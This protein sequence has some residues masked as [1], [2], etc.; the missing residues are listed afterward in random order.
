MKHSLL[1]LSILALLLTITTTCFAY[2]FE[3]D[4]IYY[5]ILS[6][7]KKI[8]EI[9]CYKNSVASNYSGD[10]VIPNNVEYGGGSYTVEVIGTYAFYCSGI[11]SISIPSSIKIINPGAFKNCQNLFSVEIPNSTEE[12]WE[13]AFYNCNRL[14]YISLPNSIKSIKKDAFGRCSNL[15]SVSINCKYV[16]SWFSNNY[17]LNTVLLGGNVEEIGNNAFSDCRTLTNVE[18]SNAI[19]KIGANAFHY[20]FS[21]TSIELPE[22]LEEIEDYAFSYCE[23]LSSIKLPNK[24]STIGCQAFAYCSALLSIEIPSH[25][26]SIGQGAFVGC[27]SLESISLPNSL[28]SLGWSAFEGCTSLE[29]VD[30]QEIT[31]LEGSLFKNCTALTSVT[32]HEGLVSIG[33]SAFDGCSSLKR[34]IIPKSVKSIGYDAFKGCSNLTLSILHENPIKLENEIGA[35]SLIVPKGSTVEYAKA[36]YWKEA[37]KIYALDGTTKRFPVFFEQYGATIITMD[38]NY[39]SGIEVSENESIR[40]KTNSDFSQCDLIMRGG[41]EITDSIINGEY[42]FQPSPYW[43]DNVIASYSYGKKIVDVTTSGTL[44]DIIGIENVN[45]IESIKINGELNGTDILTIR[46]M[47][48]LKLL[49]LKD[50]KIVN[51]GMSYYKEYVTSENKIGVYFFKDI[52]KLIHITLPTNIEDID[53]NLLGECP[54]LVSL[55]IPQNVTHIYQ[56]SN[57]EEDKTKSITFLCPSASTSAASLKLVVLGDKVETISFG[58][59]NIRR[60][61]MGNCKL[62][63]IN[64]ITCEKLESF[65]IPEGVEKINH[66]TFR[67]CNSLASIEFPQSLKSIDFSAFEDCK[68]LTSVVIPNNVNELHGGVFSG[69]RS[70][71]HI[72]LPISLQEIEDVMFSGCTSLKTIEI[73]ESVTKIGRSAFGDC[74]KLKE[75]VIP[76]GVTEIDSYAFSGCTS[77]KSISLPPNIKSIDYLF[78]GC[79]NLTE[80]TVPDGVN[81]M[82]SAFYGC[83]NLSKINIPR[84]VIDLGGSDFGHCYRLESIVIPNNVKSIGKKDERDGAFYR[85]GKLKSVIFEDSSEKVTIAPGTFMGTAIDTLYIGRNIDRTISWSSDGT[86]RSTL[87]SVA[88]G[89]NVTFVGNTVFANCYDI[90][91]VYS[92]NPTPPEIEENTFDNHNYQNATLYIP[93][94]SKTLYWLHPYWEKFFNMVDSLPTF[95]EHINNDNWSSK[96]GFYYNLN[97]TKVDDNSLGKGIYIKN[98]KKIIIK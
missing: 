95:I 77:L 85:C 28:S 53:C 9:C 24:V 62:K 47:T 44:I 65:K 4:G 12:I 41:F 56:L 88:I 81:S 1:R 33:R 61:L 75:I 18:L 16:G 73:P 79:S 82:V 94:G 51:G 8:V 23:S 2:D 76:N 29:N 69:C 42:S 30:I 63:N 34:L 32:L 25:V 22:N 59:R 84:S 52:E 7:E 66:E 3:V 21:L 40:I 19:K 20:C 15:F 83:H 64:G 70:L 54:N 38:G 43:W 78:C 31:S 86:F 80:I 72:K 17:S 74:T 55:T 97:G 67:W 90:Q 6:E 11:T 37:D 58:G 14:K 13:E 48:N 71:S 39:E 50:A 45:N 46:K 89:Q 26:T 96:N 60:I 87:R 35:I 49:N 93:Q 57:N 92:F 27:V 36:D 68:S 98:G 91:S 5:N 10:F